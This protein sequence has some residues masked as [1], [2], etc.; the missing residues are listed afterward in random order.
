MGLESVYGVEFGEFRSLEV[1]LLT[2][3]L[4]DDDIQAANLFTT[5]PQIAEE[6]FVVLEDPENLFGAQ[7]VTPLINSEQVDETARG[8]ID[9]VSSALTTEELTELNKRIVVDN[10]N[11][12]DVAQEWLA[13]Q[14]LA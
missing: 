3:A 1:A 8:I 13:E 11:A 4:T 14:G 2:K 12:A 7:N 6:G 9:G 5:D 10:E